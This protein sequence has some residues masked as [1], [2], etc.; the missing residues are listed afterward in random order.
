MKKQYGTVKKYDYPLIIDAY[1]EEVGEAQEIDLI[2]G[3]NKST[4]VQTGELKY[5]YTEFKLATVSSNNN[6]A[7]ANADALTYEVK[8]DGIAVS[9]DIAKIT[10]S[11]DSNGAFLMKLYATVAGDYTITPIV[12]GNNVASGV[13]RGEAIQITVSEDPEITEIQVTGLK[14]DGKAYATT[15]KTKTVGLNFVHRYANGEEGSVPVEKNSIEI[16][17]IEEQY[18]S[19]ADTY[20]EVENEKVTGLV[21]KANDL[22]ID[23]TTLEIAVTDENGKTTK[24]EIKVK[25]EESPTEGIVF[26]GATILSQG[27]TAKTVT[28][29]R[30]TIKAADDTNETRE[31]TIQQSGTNTTSL[32]AILPIQL[33]KDGKPTSVRYGDIVEEGLTNANGTIGIYETADSQ[34]K[35]TADIVIKYYSRVDDKY[36]PV[37]NPVADSK[38]DAIGIALSPTIHE[39][40]DP[41]GDPG[42]T[43]IDYLSQGL[44][45]QYDTL[46]GRGELNIP[47]RIFEDGKNL[48]EQN[49][50]NTVS[51]DDE[52]EVE[53]NKV[54]TTSTPV[55]EPETSTKQI[56]KSTNSEVQIEKP[57][58]EE[59]PAVP[60]ETVE[61]STPVVEP[62]TK[63]VVTETPEV[64]PTEPETP[65]QGE[66]EVTDEE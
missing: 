55:V 11:P 29:Y 59:T 43:G 16:T 38:V 30:D 44:T 45:I 28:L 56:T 53:E 58:T 37:L 3:L 35:T 54:T 42:K 60:E 15:G 17:K 4:D 13:K 19:K 39:E 57:T 61:P 23:E 12:V 18:I 49:N 31:Y 25:I 34:Y 7:I 10:Y 50:A 22:E 24:K 26:N 47:V 27:A 9:E 1:P 20:F 62:E 21:I 33:V 63:P 64:K 5:R 65:I 66:A 52:V 51:S 41:D 2:Q 8:K 40:V 46:A 48:L 14:E 6:V 36:E 32:I